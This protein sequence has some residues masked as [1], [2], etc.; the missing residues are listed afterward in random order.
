[1]FPILTTP[2]S[3][4]AEAL[5]P[6]TR[7]RLKRAARLL[8]GALLL[9]SLVYLGR[10]FATLD[11]AQLASVESPQ[12]LLLG[13]IAVPVYAALLA[14]LAWGWC[15]QAG[16]GRLL[17]PS[18]AV[19]V[20]GRAVIAKYVPGSVLQ[21]A[22]RQW[23]GGTLGLRQTAMARASATEIALHVLFSGL[24][25]AAFI[26]AGSEAVPLGVAASALVGALLLVALRWQQ[27]RAP[28][29]GQ[30]AFF[31]GFAL[32]VFVL[33][34]SG[35]GDAGSAA[36]WTGWFFAAWLAGFLVPLAPGGIGVREAVLVAL[37]GPV[38]RGG[39]VLAFALLLRAVTL[40]G[41]GA[42]GATAYL[43]RIRT[44]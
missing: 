40:L 3:S 1:M 10:R 27:A 21:Y 23:L 4:P 5:G 22:S 20:Y 24:M 33:A 7:G 29:I 31:V 8:G 26:A 36:R 17:S 44:R 13:T 34:A 28:L 9:V 42:F 38:D 37:A 11:W 43:I 39:A 2:A 6:K 41:D 30:A 19:A 25:A 15:R 18:A 32:L 35:G 16:E 12:A 14:A